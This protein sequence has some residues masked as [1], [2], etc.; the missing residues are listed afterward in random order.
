[1]RS[2]LLCTIA[3]FTFY[4]SPK[5]NFEKEEETIRRMLEQERKA[6]F[7]KDVDMFVAE[8]ADSMISV[9]KGIVRKLSTEQNKNRIE[10]YFKSVE[11][12]KWDDTERPV[13]KFSDDGTLA[14]AVVQKQ[15]VLTYPDSLGNPFID[16]TNYAWVSIY[17]KGKSGWKVETNIS[18]T[19]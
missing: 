19:K 13:I 16:T 6:H 2:F 15:V 7:N 3:L 9:N 14:Y 18:T 11:F 10:P 17:R 1:M 4:C 12:I 8:F 5:T